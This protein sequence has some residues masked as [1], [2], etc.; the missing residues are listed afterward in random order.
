MKKSL[1]GIA[2]SMML[3]CWVAPPTIAQQRADSG[4]AQVVSEHYQVLS[5][6]GTGDATTLSRELESRFAL[7]NRIFHFNDNE[8][9]FPLKVRAYKD[10]QAYDDYVAARLSD[11]RSGAVYLHY[12]QPDRREL[13]VHRNSVDEERMFPHQA[14]IQYLRAFIPYPPAWLRE[15]FAI[16]FNTLKFDTGTTAS[17][18]GASGALLPGRAL[19]GGGL[20]YEENLSWLEVVKNLG[21]SAPSLEAI[22]RAD[23]DGMPEHVENFPSVSWALVSFFMNSEKDY[24]Y[25]RILFESF[26]VLSRSA[27]AIGNSEAMLNHIASWVPLDTL[28][29]DYKN[30]LD[31]RKTFAEL[32]AEGQQA[33]S[34]KNFSQAEALFL[35]ALNQ[36]PTH[37]APYYYLG[38]IAYEVKN[39]DQAEQFYRSA[40]Q[41][42]AET[43]LVSYARGLNAAS[44]GRSAE[45]ISYLEQAAASSEYRERANT[46]ITRL[47]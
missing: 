37:F 23:I 22:L 9:L 1:W 29:K 32:I 39:Y 46:L 2:V 4:M 42:G 21:S 45:A 44:A 35:S 41:Y 15:G 30:Y 14:F 47:R 7:Y 33:Y 20:V 13:V 36:K 12:N 25:T 17:S 6:S 24:Y 18:K 27:S 8:V 38:L 31:S 5:D 26:M 11:N 16:Y 34:R 19:S 40:L 3:F 43:A 28:K 10:K